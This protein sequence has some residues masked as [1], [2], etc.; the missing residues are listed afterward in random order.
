MQGRP[1]DHIVL[2]VK[3][4]DRAERTFQDL[5][6]QLTPRAFHEDRMGT[7]N[8]L[9]QFADRT[10]LEILEVDR[11]ERLDPH[12]FDASDP[13]FSFGQHHLNA[14]TSAGEGISM[15]A[16][17]SEDTRADVAAWRSA[18]IPTYR[19]LD[20]ERQAKLPDGSTTTIAFSLGFATSER[21][22]GFAYFVCQDRTA[23]AFW[24]PE[25]QTH[26]NGATGISAVYAASDAPMEDARFAGQLFGGAIAETADGASVTCG[27]HHQIRFVSHQAAR[28]LDPAMQDVEIEGT[29]VIGF[30][31]T[32]PRDR[33]RL[34]SGDG[35]GAFIGFGF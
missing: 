21:M 2:A 13:F 19:P 32:G 31:L 6:F 1:F 27:G 14:L 4:L 15:L 26:P 30:D 18:D 17:A 22:P 28:L 10:F 34:S 23:D 25:Y 12:N 33:Q 3:D 9:A 5:G 7:S 35:H 11:P 8:R 24:K 20:F 29:R 16:F